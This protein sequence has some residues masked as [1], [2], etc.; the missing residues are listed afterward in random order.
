MKFRKNENGSI[1]LE[2]AMM[3]PLFLAF[4]LVL[5]AIIRLTVVQ[6][7]LQNATSEMT[8]QVATHIYPVS[9]VYDKLQGSAL[10]EALQQVY[11]LTTSSDAR[12]EKAGELMDQQVDKLITDPIANALEQEMEKQKLAP[13][14][15]HV[16]TDFV[17]ENMLSVA[18]DEIKDMLKDAVLNPIQDANESLD[19]YTDRMKKQ[20]Q[21]RLDSVVK[22]AFRPF[23]MSFMDSTYI[24]KKHVNIAKLTMPNFSDEHPKFGVEVEYT[25]KVIVPFMSYDLTLRSRSME[26]VWSGLK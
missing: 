8:K 21:D 9:Y 22:N 17:K 24:D 3:L 16:I 26:R 20:V 5:I 2:A 6:M 14:I 18:S 4:V 12:T 23:V 13:E 1:T 25:V 19:Q 10:G 7:I 15:S 11:D